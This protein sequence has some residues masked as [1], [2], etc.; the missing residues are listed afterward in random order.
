MVWL[1]NARAGQP[2][3]HHINNDGEGRRSGLAN[4]AHGLQLAAAAGLTASKKRNS[5]V[6]KSVHGESG[7]VDAATAD[8]RRSSRLAEL[9]ESYADSD[10]FNL[11]E[12]ALFI[13]CCRAAPSQPKGGAC[14]GLKQ[15]K[16]RVTVPFGQMPQVKRRCRYS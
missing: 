4:G 12:A 3:R 14:S 16:D 10:M 15:R 2:S 6:S 5:V 13:K 9:R 8:N 7:T 1:R 11:D